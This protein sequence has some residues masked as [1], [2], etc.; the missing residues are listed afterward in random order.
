MSC[1]IDYIE[2]QFRES[3][4]TLADSLND[5]FAAVRDKVLESKLFKPANDGTGRY[6]F[7]EESKNITAY[8]AQQEFVSTTNKS[9]EAEV[10]ENYNGA[11]RIN[12]LNLPE[13]QKELGVSTPAIKPGVD[14]LFS[15]NPELDNQV[16]ETLGFRKPGITVLPNGNLKITAF[17]TDKVGPTSKGEYQR[18]K[19]LYLSLDKPYPGEDIYTVEVEIS[20]KNLLDRKLGFGQ[21]S[22]EY[23]IDQKNKRVDK[24]LDTLHEFKQSLG[25]KAEIGSID[26]ALMNELVLFDKELINKA[27]ASKQTYNPQQEQQAKKLYSQYLD[28]I[29][30]DSKV[31]DIVYHGSKSNTVRELFTK[32]DIKKTGVSLGEGFFFS[33]RKDYVERDVYGFKTIGFYLLNIVNPING[34]PDKFLREND[35]DRVPKNNK[36]EI[37]DDYLGDNGETIYT[38]DRY[39]KFESDKERTKV[40]QQLG[41]DAVDFNKGEYSNEIVVFEPEQ[42]HILGGKQDIEG[43]KT[44]VENVSSTAVMIA[45]KDAFEIDAMLDEDTR[46]KLAYLRGTNTLTI[47]C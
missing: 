31:K 11:V 28:T 39:I 15:S 29:F 8:N 46:A 44:F 12:V 2:D 6:L 37:K 34:N 20:P 33:R 36:S 18:G 16:Y 38:V 22:E 13:A 43:F 21:I 17:R 26:G 45:G 42:I 4:P 7:A 5:T 40:L 14:E 41:Y 23:F 35:F 1:R 24:Q 30:P 19:G 47:E 10:I 27:L 9:Y 25:I 32:E 3:N